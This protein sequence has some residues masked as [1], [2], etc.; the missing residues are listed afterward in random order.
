MSLVIV[1]R[2]LVWK[3]EVE[4]DLIGLIHNRAMAGGHFADMEMQDTGNGTEVFFRPG[5]Q[6][7]RGFRVGGVGPEND[8]V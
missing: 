4:R 3:N 8:D 7:I 1:L 2:L 6:F 5:D